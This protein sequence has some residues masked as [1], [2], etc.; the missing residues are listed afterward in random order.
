METHCFLI[1]ETEAAETRYST[2]NRELLTVYLLI[3]HFQS[4]VK[5]RQFH[6][7]TD[8]KP[9]TFALATQSSKVTLHLQPPNKRIIPFNDIY[10]VQSSPWYFFVPQLPLSLCKLTHTQTHMHIVFEFLINLALIFHDTRSIILTSF[11]SY[12]PVADACLP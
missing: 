10:G 5:G 2:F 3:K 1:K 4:F 9:L 12:N 8:H 7:I 11:H 6:V